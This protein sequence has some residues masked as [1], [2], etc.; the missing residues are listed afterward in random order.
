[1]QWREKAWWEMPMWIVVLTPFILLCRHYFF[2][3]TIIFTN[4]IKQQS[5][6]Q[7][8]QRL[9][10]QLTFLPSP[11]FFHKEFIDKMGLDQMKWRDNIP[12]PCLYFPQQ[13]WKISSNKPESRF[14]KRVYTHEGYWYHS[15]Q[16]HDPS[17][18]TSNQMKWQ[19]ITPP[20]CFYIPQQYWKISSNK[21]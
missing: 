18:M 1:M 2:S 15:W 10:G 7:T 14:V 9:Q 12:P 13:Y 4:Q 3:S 5:S 6:K 21:P 19:D 20:L 11:L 16:D 8:W 17:L